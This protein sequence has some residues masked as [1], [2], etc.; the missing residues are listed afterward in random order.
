MVSIPPVLRQ[1][2][3]WFDE[4]ATFLLSDR[5]AKKLR[6]GNTILLFLEAMLRRRPGLDAIAEH[7]RSAPWM[8]E[9]L[10]LPSIHA[11]SLHRKLETLP[12]DSLQALVEQAM[13]ELAEAYQND[14]L[15]KLGP[16][17]AVDATTIS[18]GAKRGEWAYVQPGQHAVNLHK[19]SAGTE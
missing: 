7:L 11:S 12:T 2:F 5:Y 16:L 4:H 18:I 17:A 8:Q 1:L 3:S 9:W 10:Q 6:G 14:S 15:A 19:V 13:A